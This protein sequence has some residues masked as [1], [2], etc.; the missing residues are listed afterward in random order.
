MD[1]QFSVSVPPEDSASKTCAGAGP[2][3][4]PSNSN[5][6]D[7]I[8]FS[9]SESSNS[10]DEDDDIWNRP[11]VKNSFAQLTDQELIRNLV[12]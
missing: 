10:D 9:S 2:D 11:F 6:E 4:S 12:E 1:F 7:N 3:S 5:E 8:L